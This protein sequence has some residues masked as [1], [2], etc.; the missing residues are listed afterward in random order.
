M[1]AKT[2][3]GTCHCG[4][5]R[6]EADIDLD[7]GVGR[8][9]CSVCT[10]VAQTS[11]IVKPEAFRLLSGSEHLGVYEWGAKVSRRM[12]CSHCGIHCFARGHLAEL[13]GD[14]VSVNVNCL[15]DVDLAGVKVSYWDGRHNNWE[16]G[17]RDRP[18]PIAA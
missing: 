8:C 15:D 3:S 10:K 13:G 9:N 11:A 1:S 5:T 18:W 4:A 2:Y 7:Q 17:P 14:Y 16:G 6:F 12:F